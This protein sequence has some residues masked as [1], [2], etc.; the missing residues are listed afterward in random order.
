[1][2]YLVRDY[3]GQNEEDEESKP[4]KNDRIKTT[5]NSFPISPSL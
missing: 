4:N 5:K 3:R 1:M 2:E